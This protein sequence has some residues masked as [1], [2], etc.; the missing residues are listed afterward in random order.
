MTNHRF[1]GL[2]A[3]VLLALAPPPVL[4]DGFRWADHARKPDDWFGGAEGKKTAENILSHQAPNGSWPKNIDTASKP[5]Q[6]DPKSLRGTF[7][8]GATLGE[9]R[10][11]ARAHEATG[12]PRC[13]AA[14]L[15]T[16]DS[17]LEA[18]Y[19]SGG[20]PQSYPPGTSYARH[21]TFNDDTMVN[22]LKFLRDVAGSP[23]FE[24]V[25]GPR[26]QRA[27]EAFDRGIQCIVKCQ[28][29]SGGKPTVWCA[30]HD[31]VTLA[32]R[33]GRSYEHPSLSGAESAGIVRFLM[34]LENPSPEVARAI[35][36]ACRWYEEAKLLGIREVRREGDKII[37]KDPEAPPL[38]A[39]FYEI[40]S[41]RPIFSGRDGVIKFD[42]AEIEHERRNGYAW[43]GRW[44]SEVLEE[45]TRWKAKHPE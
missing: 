8:N 12:E 20:W 23:A 13:K 43:Y 28:I 5:Y 37:V 39:R 18:Q 40:N 32:P 6:G 33:K 34:S 15:K 16:L 45:W 7:D 17:I 31:E 19:P 42:M 2:C 36:A 11:L 41:N 24:A 25:D 1:H 29:N 44:G 4:A 30:Q 27:K 3:C 14:L 21:I 9:A 10:F 38:W 22:I 35:R 26:R